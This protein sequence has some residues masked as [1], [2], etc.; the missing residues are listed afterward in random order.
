MP[1][2]A[3]PTSSRIMLHVR[4][5]RLE[6]QNR[7]FKRFATSLH[8]FGKADCFPPQ[9]VLDF[10]KSRGGSSSAVERQLP[11]LD[12]A[13]SIPVSRSIHPRTCSSGSL[14]SSSALVATGG[15]PSYTFSIVSGSL[16]GL[17]LNSSAGAITGTPTSL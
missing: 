5:F 13:G 15:V 11:K 10:D 1:G 16:P 17:T 3:R 12:V 7:T 4:S 6:E 2:S 14:A 8:S 9:P